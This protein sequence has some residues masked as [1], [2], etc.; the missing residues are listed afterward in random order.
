MKSFIEEIYCGN[1]RPWEKAFVKDSKYQKIAM[2]FSM[3]ENELINFLDGKEKELFNKLL[4]LH[5][6]L[7][8][9]SCREYYAEGVRFG[10]RLM[11]DVY[12]NGSKN[13]KSEVE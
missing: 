5:S 3:A 12:E 4:K 1:I 11:T 8:E 7:I 2:N 10:V 9:L 13:F 6:D